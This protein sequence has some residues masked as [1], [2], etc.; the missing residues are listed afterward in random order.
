MAP[1]H[2][3]AEIAFLRRLREEL[4]AWRA[5]GIL[6]DRQAD[7]IRARYDFSLVDRATGRERN[8]TV[9]IVTLA[10]SA[11][12]GLGVVLFFAA[13]WPGIARWGRFAIVLSAMAA[14]FGAGFELGWRR[15]T[16]PL[17]GR[18]LVVAG[19]LLYGAGIWLIAQTFNISSHE[20]NGLLFWALGVLPLAAVLRVSPLVTLYAILLV[21]WTVLETGSFDR[22]NP[23]YFPVA[24]CTTLP[25][26][27]R[28]RLRFPLCTTVL[29]LTL[30][31]GF[32]CIHW[33]GG[34]RW[35]RA[36][37]AL[38]PV[39]LAWGALLV[40]LGSV[41]GRF[42][43][44]VPF[45]PAFRVPGHILLA[46]LLPLLTFRDALSHLAQAPVP[47]IPARLFLLAACVAAAGLLAL[48]MRR[49]PAVPGLLSRGPELLCAGCVVGGVTALSLSPRALPA[50]GWALL[51]NLLYIALSAALVFVA[52]R[53]RAWFLGY[54]GVVMFTALVVC[55]YLEFAVRLMPKSFVFLAA[56]G[57]L[58]AG[59][60]F[61]ER[62]RKAARQETGPEGTR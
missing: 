56:G 2:S 42:E 43:R 39:L 49:V 32:D 44:W 10:G 33:H 59:G 50:W 48:E 18:A 16:F 27:Y 54:L 14:L 37:W 7:E 19:C 53:T 30:A 62:R 22:P 35:S 58:L 52:D 8:R 25:L 23:L 51:F 55:R 26:V 29:A 6:T 34:H 13:N 36:E 24:I 20:P 31:L 40:L 57:L 21:S 5:D 45:R 3:T 11:L 1:G 41:H 4:S 28:D 38:P 46:G 15:G 60:L 17:T 61:L 12:L 47:A 9:A